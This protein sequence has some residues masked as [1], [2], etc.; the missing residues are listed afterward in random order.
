VSEVEVL[1]YLKKALGVITKRLEESGVVVLP[2][3]TDHSFM[4]LVK[5][6]DTGVAIKVSGRLVKVKNVGDAPVYA[7]FDRP[8]ADEYTVAFPGSYILVPRLTQ[9]VYLR[10][11]TGYSTVVS[12]EVLR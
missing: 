11:P 10:A 6:S 3:F 9:Y 1:N 8:V 4:P 2:G 7:N 5:V 12:V